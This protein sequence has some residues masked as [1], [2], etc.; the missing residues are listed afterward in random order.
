MCVCKYESACVCVCTSTF[1]SAYTKSSTLLRAFAC[2][3]CA[4]AFPSPL[5]TLVLLCFR[6]KA[7]RDELCCLCVSRCVTHE[8]EIGGIELAPTAGRQA[9][10]SELRREKRRK[11][12]CVG[13]R[14][15]VYVCERVCICACVCVCVCA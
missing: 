8:S 2:V 9:K 11:V 13:V 1:A 3:A 12:G 15:C 14:V 5:C 6:D 7:G 10:R 4:P